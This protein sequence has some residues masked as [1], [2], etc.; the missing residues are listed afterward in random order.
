MSRL[1]QIALSKRSVTLLFAGALFIAGLSAW[2]SL[3]QELLPDI[4]FPVVTVVTPFPGAGSSDVTEQVTKPIEN[5]MSGIPRLET[6][7]STSSNSIS[8]VIAQ[9]SFGTDVK[10]TT[11]AIDEAIAKANLPAT[12]LADRPGPQHQCVAGR[13]L[14]DR[15]DRHGHPRRCRRDRAARDRPR[16]RS[17]RRRRPRRPDRRSRAAGLRDARP[18]EDGRGGHHQPAGRRHPPGEQPDRAVG[19]DRDRRLEGPGVDHRHVHVRGA[20]QGPRRRVHEAGRGRPAPAASAAP[21]RLGGAERRPGRA[22]APITI[23]DLGYGRHG[24]RGDHR[25]RPDQRRPGPDRHRLQAVERE[26]RR[27]GRRGPGQAGR[28][29]RSVT[30]IS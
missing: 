26:H 21:R 15:V 23:G 8:L 24:A 25:L 4:D 9:F 30:R 28:D 29:R 27:S 18:E 5:A 10:A 7:Q 6:I 3:K 2:G 13:H 1:S 11:Q 16:A 20:D 22:A 19:A 12:G 14:V 17:D